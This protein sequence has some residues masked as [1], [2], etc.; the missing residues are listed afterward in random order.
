[1]KKILVGICAATMMSVPAF[2]AEATNA[3]SPKHTAVVTQKSPVVQYTL[4]INNK[5][6]ELGTEKIV[7]MEDQIMVPLKITSEA[8]GFTL[9]LDEQK[10]TIHMDNGTMQTD[11]TVG[12]DTYFAYSS[13]AIGMT[14]PL[15]LGVAPAII[16]GSIYVPVDLYKVLLTDP[17]C[18]SIKDH[19]INI[20]TDSMTS[21]KPASIGL[22]NPLVNYST[23]DEARKAAGFT[24]AVPA[25]LPDGYQMKD[26]TVIS[27]SLA[28]I[29]YS[30]GDNHI[31]Y[32]TAKG[33]ADISGDY[34]VYDKVKPITVGNT[35]ITVKGKGDSI[36]LATWTKD[37]TSFSLSFDVPINEKTLSTIIEGIN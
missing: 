6:V 18:V 32:R 21:K 15:S 23:L 16:E 5:T 26:I 31:A 10:Q 37:G 4:K 9:K 20:S 7:L 3:L 14:A 28:K 35:K 13:K 27:N 1:M 22:P 19:V 34:N 36:N 29:S 17:N 33:N 12:E 2:A 30:K 24:F 25:T 11:L 8:L